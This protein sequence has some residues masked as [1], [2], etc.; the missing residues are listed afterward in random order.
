MQLGINLSCLFLSWF[1]LVIFYDLVWFGG[2]FGLVYW[3]LFYVVLGSVFV[4]LKCVK[5]SVFRSSKEI[6]HGRFRVVQMK[7]PWCFKKI[8]RVLQKVFSVEVLGV[9]WEH[10][11]GV[12]RKF[13][14]CFRSVF[15]VVWWMLQRSFE[16]VSRQFL[17]DFNKVPRCF[18]KV[19]G[20]CWEHF[21]GVS[22]KF[23]GV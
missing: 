3:V 15:K 4:H 14:G 10:F 8:S 6:I 21:K 19:S 17:E 13:R 23:E 1:C 7:L 9:C 11:K 16:A 2:C 18:M 12:S 20:V 22:R 5:D